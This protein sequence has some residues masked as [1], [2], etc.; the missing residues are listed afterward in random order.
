MSSRIVLIGGGEHAR[1]VAD[2]FLAAGREG[3]LIGY[4]D[5]APVEQMMKRTGLAFLGWDDA[6][7]WDG[8]LAVLGLG[9]LAGASV[10]RAAVQRLAGRVGGWASVI[11]PAATVARRVAIGAGTVVMAGVTLNTGAEVGPHV[12][13]NTGAIV[14]HDVV[15][16]AHTQVSPGAVLGGGVRV[17]EGVF[18]G[19]GA[20]VRDHV[21]IGEGSVVGMGAVVTK[22]VPAGV[23]AMGHP[24][25]HRS[26]GR[27]G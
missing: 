2:A 16:G 25:R 9:G 22:D 12:V 3:E 19:L 20:V 5:R 18:I 26:L 23:L 21:T 11:H 17:G 8:E 4:L 6:F 27:E 13:V 1:V 24:A 10:R 15:L 7:A 14:E